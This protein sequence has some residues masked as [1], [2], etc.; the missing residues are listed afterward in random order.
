MPKAK[1]QSTIA[2]LLD[3]FNEQTMLIFLVII[4]LVCV[5]VLLFRQNRSI[6]IIEP[7]APVT[8]EQ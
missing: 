6:Q 2:N 3:K 4:L 7:V 5:G 1:K 8:A